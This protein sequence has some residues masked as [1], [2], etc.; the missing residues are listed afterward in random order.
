MAQVRKFQNAGKTDPIPK[1]QM[2]DVEGL[3]Q[4]DPENLITRFSQNPNQ[5]FATTGAAPKY[6]DAVITR[7][8]QILDMGKKYG[9][10]LDNTGTFTFQNPIEGDAG[11]NDIYKSTGQFPKKGIFGIGGTRMDDNAINNLA[12]HAIEQM[13]RNQGN[14][15]NQTAIPNSLDNPDLLS[16]VDA[17]KQTSTTNKQDSPRNSAYGGIDWGSLQKQI[18]SGNDIDSF[19][20]IYGEGSPRYQLIQPLLQKEVERLSDP[21]WE[22]SN[23]WNNS[24][25]TRNE[26]IARLQNA[27]EALKS[28]DWEVAEKALYPLGGVQALRQFLDPNYTPQGQKSQLKYYSGNGQIPDWVNQEDYRA[29]RY[30]LGNQP[31]GVKQDPTSGSLIYT[32][33]GSE[34]P[35]QSD[36]SD[37]DYNFTPFQNYQ[38][39]FL[40]NGQLMRND[41]PNLSWELKQ[42]VAQSRNVSEQ[43]QIG[44]NLLFSIDQNVQPISKIIGDTSRTGFYYG[45]VTS[46]FP[47]IGNGNQLI[48]F[49]KENQK[50]GLPKN[51]MYRSKDGKN[52][53]GTLSYTPEGQITFTGRFNNSQSSPYI[54]IPLGTQYNR[55]QQPLPLSKSGLVHYKYNDKVNT[56]AMLE[57]G[58]RNMKSGVYDNDPTTRWQIYQKMSKLKDNNAKWR[59]NDK[60]LD[61]IDNNGQVRSIYFRDLIRKQNLEFLMK[62]QVILLIIKEEC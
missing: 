8:G 2:I 18:L 12:Y 22:Q 47:E 14:Q 1:T 51:Y 35:I 41:D 58:Q 13:I 19:Y 28:N 27:S 15:G 3:G 59:V 31:I 60:T 39:T 44:G 55:N 6:R 57:I 48:G 34:E 61:V 16:R 32:Y 50:S 37:F 11:V 4:V 33:P 62:Y 38:G 24:N 9:M 25:I 17:W 10:K 7:M 26:Y 42:L 30:R 49:Y 45:D 36:Y 29:I 56:G 54:Q 53:Y 46:M 23:R 52:Y 5:W 21:N 43:N 20:K 40:H